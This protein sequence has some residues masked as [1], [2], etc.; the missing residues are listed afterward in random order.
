MIDIKKYT[1]KI[2]QKQVDLLDILH[3][4]IALVSSILPTDTLVSDQQ[5]VGNA[6]QIVGNNNSN[7]PVAA[8]ILV[9]GI[10][11]LFKPPVNAFLCIGGLSLAGYG[12]YKKKDSGSNKQ[13][14]QCQQEVDYHGLVSQI[15][16]ELAQTSRNLVD[17]WE[18]FLADMKNQLKREILGSDQSVDCKSEMLNIATT[19][20]V[21]ECTVT[22]LYPRLIAAA[23]KKSVGSINVVLR[24]FENNYQNA[25]IDTC[26]KQVEIWSK[27]M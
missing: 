25:I 6:N 4:D 9:A 13:T 23:N 5:N 22:S 17:A 16:R 8:G 1:D 15:N 2:G 24:E 11:L 7:L 10:G 19:T 20:T 3:R 27:I 12:I 14:V 21:L 18:S 26:Q